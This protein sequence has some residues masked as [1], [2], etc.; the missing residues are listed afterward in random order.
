M[1]Q[2]E[3]RSRI[4]GRSGDDLPALAGEKQCG[5]S[6]KPVELPVMNMVFATSY[7]ASPQSDRPLSSIDAMIQRPS[8]RTRFAISRPQ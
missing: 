5:G 7:F 3:P 8:M 4:A 1:T 2:P 6:P